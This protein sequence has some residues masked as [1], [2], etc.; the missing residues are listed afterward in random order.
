MM[1][2]ASLQSIGNVGFR[3]GIDRSI[4]GMA[5]TGEARPKVIDTKAVCAEFV[6][7]TMFVVIGCGTAC[8][9]GA[10]TGETRLIVAFAFGMA[11]LVLAYS[12][13]H[14][15]GG[16]INCAVTFALVL[17]GQV[18]WYQGIAN[19]IAQ[20]LGSVA[21]SII[22]L[23]IFPCEL[24]LTTTLGT[25]IIA[26]SRSEAF[27]AEVFGTF[28][29][30]FV[31]FET[32]VTPQ[33]SCGKNACIAIGFTVFLAH[34]LMLPIDGCSI[35]PTRSFG[36]AIIS[37]IRSCENYTEGGLDD[38]W[39]MWLAPLIGAAVAVIIQAAF[40]P[41][42]PKGGFTSFGAMTTEKDVYPARGTG[43]DDAEA[44]QLPDGWE[45]EKTAATSRTGTGG[46]ATGRP[47][48]PSCMRVFGMEAGLSARRTST[49]H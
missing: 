3:W 15:S 26:R 35:N 28:I 38:L 30:C 11:I 46:A 48:W 22:L 34:V 45:T 32:A 8:V 24:D 17:Q 29:L 27:A 39:I 41:P 1:N 21:G 36:P 4:M 37:K 7:M 42:T 2:I 12:I 6:A 20:M 14:H 33:A 25:N 9:N 16:H 5:A 31:V 47:C 18:P 19:T 10:S 23:I 40:A 49:G 44:D 13:G 43:G